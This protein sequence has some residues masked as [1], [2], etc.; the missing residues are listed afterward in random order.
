M[1]RRGSV[2]PQDS[3]FLRRDAGNAEHKDGHR[4]ELAINCDG[5]PLIRSVATGQWWALGWGDLIDLAREAGIDNATED[6]S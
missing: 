1:D 3:M 4:Y 6:G 2:F 5:L